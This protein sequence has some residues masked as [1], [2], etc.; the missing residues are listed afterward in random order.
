MSYILNT[1]NQK[2]GV[3][4]PNWQGAQLPAADAIYGKYCTLQ[5]LDPKKHISELFEAFSL[6]RNGLNYTYLPYGPFKDISEFSRWITKIVHET[7]PFFF[8]IIDANTSKA[9]GLASLMRIDPYIGTIEV[10]H[11][12]FSPLLQRKTAA[13]EAMYLLMKYSFELGY[14]RYEWK[15]DHLNGPSIGAALRLGFQ[16][17]GTFRQASVV[18]GH[19]RDTDWFSILDSEWPLLKAAFEAW[20]EEKNFD[21]NGL[22]KISLSEL[23]K[24][25]K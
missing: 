3:S 24:G 10:G 16:F 8:A 15:C 4:L 17:E 12:S 5:K 19:N 6:D 13:T 23:T 9:V 25:F 11:I 7:D 2:I 20:L 14:R 22:Q 18:K 1:F 21:Q